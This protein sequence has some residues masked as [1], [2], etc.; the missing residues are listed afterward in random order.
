MSVLD[1]THFLR[2]LWR[3][4]LAQIPSVHVYT[5]CTVLPQSWL[6]LPVLVSLVV[7]TALCKVLCGYCVDVVCGLRFMPHASPLFTFLRY[8]TVPIAGVSMVLFWLTA[9]LFFKRMLDQ[10]MTQRSASGD[11]INRDGSK[12]CRGFVILLAATTYLTFGF[13]ASISPTVSGRS[14]KRASARPTDRNKISCVRRARACIH[15]RTCT[16]SR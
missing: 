14:F 13:A 1:S 2:G 4:C 11:L 9:I 6:Q 12:W 3:M 15:T 8:F 5:Y 10:D 7:S 16:L